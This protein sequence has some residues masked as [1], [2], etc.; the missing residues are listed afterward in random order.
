MRGATA[1]LFAKNPAAARIVTADL[2]TEWTAI[3]R[4][5]PEAI[6]IE[7]KIRLGEEFIRQ[8]LLKNQ[9]S[10][11]IVQQTQ[12]QS[13]R[14]TEINGDLSR[15]VLAPDELAHKV[16]SLMQQVML[17]HETPVSQE[18]LGNLR[19]MLALLARMPVQPSPPAQSEPG[20]AA[21]S[22]NCANC[23]SRPANAVLIPCG[24]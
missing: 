14:L 18:L 1:A 4:Q 23:C 7:R 12:E 21:A 3:Y 6:R 9:L 17:D 15:G 19:T 22:A 8:Q 2:L 5:S 24:H 13:R 11:R 20:P 16:R 10:H